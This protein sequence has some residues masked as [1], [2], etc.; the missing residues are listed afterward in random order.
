MY[1]LSLSFFLSFL[2]NING[3]I[4]KLLA[5]D[6]DLTFYKDDTSFNKNIEVLR[7]FKKN[8]LFVIVTGRSYLDYINV[9]KNKVDCN[10]LVVNH[11][12]TIIKDNMVIKS[13]S[14]NKDTIRKLKKIFNF[15]S[16]KYFATSNLE[17]RVDINHDEISKI[18]IE[19]ENI[20]EA[21]KAVKYIDNHFDDIK[22]YQLMIHKNHVEIVSKFADKKNAIEYIAEIE[23]IDNNDIYT[24]GDGYTD[25]EMIKSFHGYAIENSVDEIKKSSESI[26]DN[27]SD[28]MKKIMNY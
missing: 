5:S 8:N 11:G 27:V 28:L 15:D 22:A 23:N 26:V 17:S 3:D 6:Y 9:S 7:G 24:V 25:I 20:V 18:N 12:A 4:M 2:Y 16:L 19:L 14:I 13:N 1:E 10:Y 21:K